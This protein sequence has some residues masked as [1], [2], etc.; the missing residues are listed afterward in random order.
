MKYLVVAVLFAVLLSVNGKPQNSLKPTSEPENLE[1]YGLRDDPTQSDYGMDGDYGEETEDEEVDDEDFGSNVI[2]TLSTK[3]SMIIAKPGDN[4]ELQCSIKN[5][6]QYVRVWNKDNLILYQGEVAMNAG[7]TM[8][9]PNQSLQITGVNES[10]VGNYTCEVLISNDQKLSV[11]HTLYIQTPPSIV[12]L[13][14]D[15]GITQFHKGQ[16]L[17]L[18]CKATGTPKPVI[19]WHK[20][21]VM[22]D[23][24]GETL[25]IDNLKP[26]DA[27]NYRCLADNKSA[28]PAHAYIEIKV[29]SEPIISI[30]KYMVNT[31]HNT[32]VE[33][34]CV[35]RGSPV[36]TTNW[37]KDGVNIKNTQS[38]NLR[39][40]KDASILLIRNVQETELG[41]YTCVAKNALGK[42]EKNVTV[43]KEP[44]VLHLKE[45]KNERGTQLSFKVESKSAIEEHELQFRKKGESEWE[46]VK[47]GVSKPDKNHV[48]HVQYTLQNQEPGTYEARAR[49][50]NSHGWSV[51]SDSKS[52]VIVQ[53]PESQAQPPAQ[54]EIT[55]KETPVGAS[56][57]G[58]SSSLSASLLVTSIALL[59]LLCSRQ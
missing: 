49:S 5:L 24:V 10:N 40:E 18:T 27:G 25:I 21:N 28:Q 1:E 55:H 54:Q 59:T 56:Q 13:T 29:E 58:A 35:V 22:L 15:N 51:Y 34:K 3:N 16:R 50:K 43:V 4:V 44:A 2:P 11:T 23:I 6:G 12:S 41:T 9:L 31:E 26:K 57:T 8:L 37:Q 42:V 45:D 33:L 46:T 14:T 38:Y 17:Q 30:D 48:Y 19:S 20:G 7:N 47:P 52:F 53:Q 39:H 36:P 32:D